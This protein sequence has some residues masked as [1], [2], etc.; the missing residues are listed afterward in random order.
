MKKEF[1]NFNAKT[2]SFSEETKGWVSFKSFIPENGISLSKQYYTMKD[3]Q[4]WKHHS[5][6]TRNQFYDQDLNYLPESHVVAIFNQE[7]SLVK[8]FNTLNY[9]GS[10]SKVQQ[11]DVYNIDKTI[12]PDNVSKKSGWYA[13]YIKTDKQKGT[14]K[15]FIEKEG[16]WFNYIRGASSLDN[17]KTSEFSFQGLG[18]VSSIQ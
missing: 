14:L 6:E 10:Q 16:K 12:R 4:L 15:E 9:E 2:L 17:N 3:G 7:P 5:N 11:Y 8:I 1:I 18:I 13:D